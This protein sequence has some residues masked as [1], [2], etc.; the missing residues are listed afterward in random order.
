[1]NES[2][3]SIFDVI[4]RRTHITAPEPALLVPYEMPLVTAASDSYRAG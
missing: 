1:M 4:L 2:F 3:L